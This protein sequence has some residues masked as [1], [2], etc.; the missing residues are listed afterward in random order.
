M[1]NK[2]TFLSNTCYNDEGK[3]SCDMFSITTGD[4]FFSVVRYFPDEKEPY[5]TGK[6]SKN[7]AY[8][9]MN[10]HIKLE[11]S[12]RKGLFLNSLGIG[13][14]IL[15]FNDND[16][17]RISNLV[18]Y[19]MLCDLKIN[20]YSSIEQSTAD[21]MSFEGERILMSGNTTMN[22]IH[23]T[24]IA[25]KVLFT[26]SGCFKSFL[27]KA[28]TIALQAGVT[29]V[30]HE[31]LPEKKV[32]RVVIT[33]EGVKTFYEPSPFD[34]TYNI[35]PELG[36]NASINVEPNEHIKYQHKGIEFKTKVTNQN[37]KL[38]YT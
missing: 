17:E 9:I 38:I 7:G 36:E 25:D 2:T 24:F 28:N 29:A 1:S 14:N 20:N 30:P 32:S 22:N 12:D 13:P 23:R 21:K 8:V 26:S 5:E 6:L 27:K 19:F 15:D 18:S 37:G 31:P 33:V 35:D 16:Y 4:N 10:E 3:V 34:I 11:Y